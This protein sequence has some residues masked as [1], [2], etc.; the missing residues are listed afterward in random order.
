MPIVS[1]ILPLIQ[2]RDVS[3]HFFWAEGCLA[4]R[5]GGVMLLAFVPAHLLIRRRGSLFLN[6]IEYRNAFWPEKNCG[7]NRHAT[8]SHIWPDLQHPLK[9]VELH[10]PSVIE[11]LQ[12]LTWRLGSLSQ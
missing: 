1:D 8:G 3:G 5:A 9:K 11:F 10:L 12:E 4:K 6:V 2:I 7:A